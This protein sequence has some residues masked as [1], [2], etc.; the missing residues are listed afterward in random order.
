MIVPLKLIGNREE[1]IFSINKEKQ[2]M[3]TARVSQWV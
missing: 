3:C 2:I 1:I